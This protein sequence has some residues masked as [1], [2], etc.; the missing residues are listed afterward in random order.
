MLEEKKQQKEQEKL[1]KEIKRKEREQKKKECEE[2]KTKEEEKKQKAIEREK[3]SEL[4][5]RKT[6][7][8]KSK[9]SAA[10][11]TSGNNE[12]T[13][14]LGLC[15]SDIEDGELTREW[16]QCTNQQYSQWMH[17]DCLKQDCMSVTAARHTSSSLWLKY[18]SLTID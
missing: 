18:S 15:E 1:E 16:V 2:K 14:C 17:S 13:V 9:R 4:N 5:Q 8:R 7:K 12:C 3:K 6:V 11:D 10:V